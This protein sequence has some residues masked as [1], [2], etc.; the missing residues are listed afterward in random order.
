MGPGTQT[1]P[2]PALLT[3]WFGEGHTYQETTELGDSDRGRWT[4]TGWWQS[5]GSLTGEGEMETGSIFRKLNVRM[6]PTSHTPVPPHHYLGVGVER[7]G[8]RCPHPA[9][10]VKLMELGLPKV[11]FQNSRR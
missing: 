5:S 8:R 4:L 2:I 7:G 9:P 10:G 1:D 6:G 3:I 11:V